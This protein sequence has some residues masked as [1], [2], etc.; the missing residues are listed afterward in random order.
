M[1]EGRNVCLLFPASIDYGETHEERQKWIN[2]F[3][4]ESVSNLSFQ[5]LEL[6][7]VNHMCRCHIF[8]SRRAVEIPD[9]K[10]KW[11]ELDDSSELLDDSGNPKKGKS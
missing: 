3:E 8:Y 6:Y 7:C 5:Y 2:A 4:V 9:G 10:P 1:D 11:S